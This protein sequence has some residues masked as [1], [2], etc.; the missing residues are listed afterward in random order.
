M[1]GQWARAAGVV[2]MQFHFGMM[3]RSGDRRRK[4]CGTI[5]ILNVLGL[6]SQF[7]NF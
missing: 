4:E 7:N 5:K 2:R 1:A 3:K 6:G